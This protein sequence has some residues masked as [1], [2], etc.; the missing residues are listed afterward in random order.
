MSL[1][2]EEAYI[3]AN[4][5][6]DEKI[7]GAG[8]VP[9]FS[10]KITENP[11]NTDTD[12]KLDI[13][14]ADGMFTTP[15]LMGAGGGIDDG[16]IERTSSW[17]S[18]KT[19]KEMLKSYDRYVRIKGISGGRNENSIELTELDNAY[20][21]PPYSLGYSWQI[22]G[23]ETSGDLLPSE[24]LTELYGEID[25]YCSSRINV[26]GT[27]ASFRSSTV[28]LNTGYGNTP[29]EVIFAGNLDKEIVV[30]VEL[31]AESTNA[32]QNKAVAEALN[33]I[34]NTYTSIGDLNTRKGTSISLV[35]NEDNT[36]KIIDALESREQFIEWFGN[37][38][39]RFGINP[40]TYGSKINEIRITKTAGTD[41]IVTAIMDSGAILSRLYTGGSLGDWSS[42][43]HTLADGYMDDGTICITGENEDS[44]G[45]YGN[46]VLPETLGF[47]R[48]AMTWAMVFI[49]LVMEL[50]WLVYQKTHK[51][52]G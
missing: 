9:G 11:N 43:G 37:S 25:D 3:L 18:E 45:M 27:S 7:G 38:N 8:G 10:P 1:R 13:E 6:T 49:E 20:R 14:T 48:D 4:D 26:G 39:D 47:S 17:S 46:G 41:A 28:Y 16:I 33:G 52:V 32:I 24:I 21:N 19:V 50:I 29:F 34:M 31:N 30:D 15:N 44:S 51:Q 40:K 36:Q 12:Y 22:T 23:V 2:A 42:T 5:Y 35:A